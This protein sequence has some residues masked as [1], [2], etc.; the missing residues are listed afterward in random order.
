M[1]VTSYLIGKKSSGGSTPNL[2][3]KSITITENGTQSVNA[4]AGYDG[5]E[6]VSITTDVPTSGG[7]DWVAIGLSEEPQSIIDG[8]N[9]AVEIMNNWDETSTMSEKFKNDYDLMFMPLVDISK[10]ST[11]ANMFQYCKQLIDVAN[12]DYSK[13]TNL[14]YLFGGCSILKYISNFN[15]NGRMQYTFNSCIALETIQGTM[16]PTN[17][18]SAFNGC[19]NL[20]SVPIIDCSKI[21]GSGTYFQNTFLDCPNLT[22]TSLNNILDSLI[23]ASGYTGTKTLKYVGF[24]STNYPTSRIEALSHYQNFVNAGWTIGY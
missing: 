2:Q 13:A 11:L 7:R 8:Y 21:T 20:K 24:T 17:L 10:A 14:D 3:N 5:L 18:R 22:D 12:L 1:D 15:A 23:S 4:D 16:K 6:N 19:T 9:Y